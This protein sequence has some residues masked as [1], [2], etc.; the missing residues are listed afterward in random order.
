M[1]ALHPTSGPT[2]VH[3][4]NLAAPFNLPNLHLIELDA[5]ENI[6]PLLHIA[7][8]L[9]SLRV[10]MSAG[11]GVSVNESLVEALQGVPY[12]KH[13]EYS[14]G[15]LRMF[16]GEDEDVVMA[17]LGQGEPMG[18]NPTGLGN[19]RGSADLLLAIG[20]TLPLLESLDLQ[21]EWFGEQAVF[22]SSAEPVCPVVSSFLFLA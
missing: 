8:R 14:A 19:S 10:R 12:L 21:A 9:Q 7:P 18:R 22:C 16:S 1:A 6:A 3:H 17:E 20:Q 4:F 11:F 13:L 5:M 2:S 15:T